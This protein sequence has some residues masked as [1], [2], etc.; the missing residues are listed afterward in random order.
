LD[1]PS[2]MDTD[3]GNAYGACIKATHTFCLGIYKPG[4]IQDYAVDCV[5]NFHFIDIGLCKNTQINSSQALALNK[6]VIDCFFEKF[7]T[8]KRN[9][10]KYTNGYC[11]LFAGSN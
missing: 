5:G 4:L 8:Q 7:R 2:G 1:L 9:L 11:L 10:N 3:Y 6:N